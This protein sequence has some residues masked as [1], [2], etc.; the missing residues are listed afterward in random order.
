MTVSPYWL[1]ILLLPLPT[2]T[3]R[4]L[5]RVPWVTYALIGI[6]VCVFCATRA[7]PTIYTRWGFVPASPAFSHL[8]T[9]QF[10]HVSVEHLF[11]NMAF[12]WLFGPHVED[13]VGRVK[14]LVLYAGGGIVA[15]L[16]HMAISV[17]LLLHGAG[18]V[19]Q[20]PLVGASGAI[21]AILAPFAVRF[22]RA[23]LRLF[24]LPGLLLPGGWGRLEMPSVAG[25]SVW[26]AQNIAGALVSLARP[27]GGGTA[28]WAHLGGFAF[29]LVAAQAAG[30][31]P[32]G[33]QDY[34]LQDARIAAGRGQTL[35]AEAIRHYRIYLD[36]APDDAP[37]RLELARALTQ[38]VDGGGDGSREEASLEMLAVVR[39]FLGQGN[40][41]DAARAVA[42]ADSLGLP[43]LLTAR[44][45][46]RLAGLAEEAGDPETAV[47]LLRLLLRE[48]PDA[49]E[50][51][52]ARLK[53][54]G[55]LCPAAPDEARA[56]L[57]SLLQKYPHSDWKARVRALLLQR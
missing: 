6:N 40:G 31:L 18:S 57:E 36:R 7:D 53:L 44:E 50:D 45:R 29:G 22:H 56:V 8:V 43:L 20:S 1:A 27:E 10:L 25:L 21:S 12:L 23:Q 30:L 41:A 17:L 48:T 55:L 19:G 34:L 14:F 26:L 42:E 39:G 13:A 37:V 46:L 54:G 38:S 4:P 9:G 3:D 28:Y 35:L 32:R 2:G 33:R 15:G 52:M 47:R 11:W 16:L 5:R 24:W 49:P 51:E